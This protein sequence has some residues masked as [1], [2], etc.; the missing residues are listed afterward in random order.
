MELTEQQIRKLRDQHR[1]LY[2]LYHYAHEVL[3]KPDISE[4]EYK[5]LLEISEMRNSQQAN[6]YIVN[7]ELTELPKNTKYYRKLQVSGEWVTRNQSPYRKD[8]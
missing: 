2:H 6:V 3:N 8:K 7:G 4:Q 5:N 1:M